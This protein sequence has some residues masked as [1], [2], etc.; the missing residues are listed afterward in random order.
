MVLK[1][2][3]ASQFVVVPTPLSVR[4]TNVVSSTGHIQFSFATLA[5]KSYT[6]QAR[7]N[8]A[9]GTWLDLLNVNGA[10]TLQQFSYPNTN[11]PVRFFR[12]R[13]L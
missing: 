12:V 3:A 6:I 5:G 11:P 10:G 7:T 13:S 9:V 4:L 8:P 2:S 1:A